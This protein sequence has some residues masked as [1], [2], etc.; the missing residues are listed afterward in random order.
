MTVEG[1]LETAVA[2]IEANPPNTLT[3]TQRA[4]CLAIWKRLGRALGKKS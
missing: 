3:N 2:A 4:L 1:D